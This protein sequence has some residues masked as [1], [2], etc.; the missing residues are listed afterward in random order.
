MG[1]QRG[2]ETD[3]MVE[4]VGRVLD[5]DQAAR[6]AGGSVLRDRGLPEKAPM[7]RKRSVGGRRW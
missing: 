1:Y 5:Q 4:D 7:K 3:A 2:K 6:V